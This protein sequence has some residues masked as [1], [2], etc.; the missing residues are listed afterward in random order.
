MKTLKVLRAQS[1]NKGVTHVDWELWDGEE[2]ID[3]A[4]WTLPG[5]A[6]QSELVRFV[7]EKIKAQSVFSSRGQMD[8]DKALL[9]RADNEKITVEYTKQ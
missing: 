1:G 4:T 9:R 5:Q 3:A 7:S 2:L 8:K 6:G